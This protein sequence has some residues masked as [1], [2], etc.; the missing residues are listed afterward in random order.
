M[1]EPLNDLT[2]QELTAV[3]TYYGRSPRYD[4]AVL[5]AIDRRRCVSSRR[6]S[7]RLPPVL[8]TTDS[9]DCRRA[10]RPSHS[11][12]ARAARSG[13]SQQIQPCAQ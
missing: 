8:A 13:C 10:C 4:L 11:R 2:P 6:D 12:R 9:P 7:A 1:N 5:R 3:A